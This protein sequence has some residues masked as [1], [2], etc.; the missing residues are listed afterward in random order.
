LVCDHVGGIA[1]EMRRP[2]TRGVEDIIERHDGGVDEGRTL[3]GKHLRID[4]AMAG[5]DRGDHGCFAAGLDQRRGKSRKRGDADHRPVGGKAEPARGRDADPQPGET[6]GADRD[7]DT[8]ER[9]I[10][11]AGRLHHLVDH[12]HQGFGV[13]ALHRQALPRAENF[14]FGVEHR[15][16]AGFQRGID[17]ENEH[18]GRI[19]FS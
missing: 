1:D 13:A 18:D 11:N 3:A 2:E 19:R 8:V 14:R 17:G 9:G 7:C 5:V 15:S 6:A 10:G 16:S 12:R 4:M